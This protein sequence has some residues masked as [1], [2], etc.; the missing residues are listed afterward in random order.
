MPQIVSV[1]SLAESDF[2]SLPRTA[3][4]HRSPGGLTLLRMIPQILPNH[5]IMH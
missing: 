3:P 1:I 4:C 5:G 2:C